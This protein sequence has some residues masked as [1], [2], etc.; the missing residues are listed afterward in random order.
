MARKCKTH[1]DCERDH[2]DPEMAAGLSNPN[3]CCECAQPLAAT[4][5]CPHGNLEVGHDV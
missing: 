3:L 5:E 4:K 1:A 2:A